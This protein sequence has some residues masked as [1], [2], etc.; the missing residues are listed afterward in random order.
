MATDFVRY[1]PEMERSIRI[2]IS[3][4]QTAGFGERGAQEPGDRGAHFVH[5]QDRLS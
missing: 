2:S 4:N 5:D 3:L 1:T